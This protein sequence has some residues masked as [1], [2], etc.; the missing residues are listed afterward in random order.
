MSQII[1]GEIDNSLIGAATVIHDARVRNSIVRREAVIEDGAEI[2]D[3]IIMDYTRVRSGARLRRVIVDRH[4]LIEKGTQIGF[5]LE[6]DAKSYAVS[7]SGVVV[8][9]RGRSPYFAR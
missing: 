9:P 2:E 6:A 8:L 3:S 7:P 5:D 4:D 1:R